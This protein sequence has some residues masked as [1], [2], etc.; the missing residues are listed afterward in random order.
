MDYLSMLRVSELANTAP[1][2][3]AIT[4]LSPYGS[5]GSV[6][7]ERI[8]GIDNGT[9]AYE[10]DYTQADLAE[11]DALIKAWCDLAFPAD[12]ERR[13]RV[14]A[15]RRRM[16]PASVTAQLAEFRALLTEFYPLVSKP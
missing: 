1:Q 14:L 12:R 3:T 5:K 6:Q 11:F 4:A 16:R 8:P 15:A 9:A 7:G 2:G 10:I 13:E